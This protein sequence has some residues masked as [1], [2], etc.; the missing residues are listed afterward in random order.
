MS[1]GLD[2]LYNHSGLERELRIPKNVVLVDEE[3]RSM[4]DSMRVSNFNMVHDRRVLKYVKV[5]I[6]DFVKKGG[7]FKN[8]N[9]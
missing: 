6:L 3:F 1:T 8:L 7:I 2:Y 4:F 5:H 9:S